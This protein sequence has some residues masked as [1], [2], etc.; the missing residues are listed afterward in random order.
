MGRLVKFIRKLF[1]HTPVPLCESNH[2]HK[3]HFS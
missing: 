2:Y 1:G 3:E